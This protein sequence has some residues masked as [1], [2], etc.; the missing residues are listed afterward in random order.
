MNRSYSNSEELLEDCKK[1]VDEFLKEFSITTINRL[2]LRYIN[3]FDLDAEVTGSIEWKKFFSVEL[4]GAIDFAQKLVYP[5]SRAMTSLQLRVDD[6]NILVRYG[7]WNQDFP[8]E[9]NR[10]EFIIDI[11]ASSR[12]ALEPIA[13]ISTLLKKYNSNI[14]KIFE[15]SIKED[16][17]NI[18]NKENV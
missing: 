8:S 5:L 14:E 10:K 16:L 13:E 15:L 4:L 2:G 1:I 6:H 12:A 18:L 7:I 9:N 17:R 11:D 3:R